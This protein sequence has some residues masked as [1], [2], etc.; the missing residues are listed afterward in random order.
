MRRIG[1][2]RT[3]KTKTLTRAKTIPPATQTPPRGMG[4]GG[5]SYNGLYGKV[6]PKRGTLFRLQVGERV[7]ISLAEV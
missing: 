6:P 2:R 7:Q 4:G 1:R 5:T 3:G